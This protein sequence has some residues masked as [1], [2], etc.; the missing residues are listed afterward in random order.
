M[1]SKIVI[2][3]LLLWLNLI[4]MILSECSL[5]SP[6][7]PCTNLEAEDC[8]YDYVVGEHCCCGQCTDPGWLYLACVLD[9]TTGSGLWQPMHSPLCP[10]EDCGSNGEWGKEIQQNVLEL[11]EDSLP[12]AMLPHQTT[13]ATTQTILGRQIKFKWRRDW[14]YHYNSLHLTSNLIP[15]VLSTTWQS[16]TATGQSWWRRNAAPPCRLP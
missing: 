16:R 1:P 13:L 14:S 4:L 10:A 5:A 15:P 6:G 8:K 3:N 2:K 9:S 12:Q 11:N 7:S